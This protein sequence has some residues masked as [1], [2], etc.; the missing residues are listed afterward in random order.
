LC[1]VMAALRP[2]GVTPPTPSS[3]RGDAHASLCPLCSAGAGVCGSA[4]IFRWPYAPWSI[5]AKS[6]FESVRFSVGV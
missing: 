1:T 5:S 3:A 2:P 4:C 6:L